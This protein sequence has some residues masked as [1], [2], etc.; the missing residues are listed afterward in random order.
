MKAKSENKKAAK[1]APKLKDLTA[2]SN[3]KGGTQ[4]GTHHAGGGGG[5]GK[6]H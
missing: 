1:P 3:P 5:A 2:K 4:A 6:V